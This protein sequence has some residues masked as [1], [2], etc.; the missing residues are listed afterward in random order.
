MPAE[1]LIFYKWIGATGGLVS[2]GMS[3]SRYDECLREYV[4]GYRYGFYDECLRKYGNANVWNTSDYF[5]LTAL[6]DN[7]VCPL[8]MLVVYLVCE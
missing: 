7:Q 6:I 1:R 4:F 2:C 5:H 8:V 3:D